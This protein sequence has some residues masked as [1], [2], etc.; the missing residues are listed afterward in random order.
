M[1]ATVLLLFSLLLV[2]PTLGETCDSQQMEER[3]QRKEEQM[4]A[5][6]RSREAEMETEIETKVEAKME[7]GWKLMETKLEAKFKADLPAA[8]AASVR[9]LPYEVVCGF[10]DVF[11]TASGTI[12][13]DRIT[14][15]FNNADRPG[16]ADG[17]LD[18][19][20]G[21]FTCLTNGHYTVAVS[22]RAVMSHGSDIGTFLYVNGVKLTE[23][24]MYSY[25][26]DSSAH[27][28]EMVSRTIVSTSYI[29]CWVL[30]VFC[31]RLSVWRPETPWS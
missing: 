26:G 7:A 3:W 20:S 24:Y 8:I 17:Q 29:I 1:A 6:W 9:D 18:I 5:R 19:E 4:E 28:I 11:Q 14:S 12:P 27:V 23:S 10:Q 13:Y 15:E 30:T 31:F 25:N 2:P 21:V 22:Y 16:G